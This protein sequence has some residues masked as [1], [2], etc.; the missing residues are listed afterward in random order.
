M[1]R[2]KSDANEKDT[3]PRV[4]IEGETF[5]SA[6]Q[7]VEYPDIEIP[8]TGETA[9]V[10]PGILW[11]RIPMPM[12]LN[13]INLWLLEDGDGWTLVDT[14]L[15]AEMC[16]EAWTM[17]AAKVFSGRPLK[18]IFVTHLHPDH[19]GLARWLQEAHKVPVWMSARGFGITKSIATEPTA[20][21]IAAAEAF[22]RHHGYL[23]AA[24]TTRFVSGKMYRSAISGVPEIAHSPNDGDDI[25]V[26]GANWRIYETNGHAEGHQCLHS[27]ERNILISGD[28]VLPT[29]SSNVSFSP[30]G[31]DSNPLASYLESLDRLGKLDAHT[32][33]LP[34]HGRPFYGLRF[35]TSDLIAHH[36][37]HLAAM[38]RACVQPLT[39]FDL[40]P[41]LFKRRL[42][43]SHWMFAMGE[44]IAH[45]EYL[46]QAG[47]MT[48]VVDG[49]GLIR[50]LHQS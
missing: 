50:Y 28:Q 36:R 20:D 13:H 35:R 11:V 24:L 37:D 19:V 21:E 48:R 8:A 2:P 39:A 17:L 27:S 18:R 26:G 9:I 16:K 47:E 44:T 1:T 29:I 40:V 4:T 15:N 5:A 38:K 49:D 22:M 45:A 3:A 32:L 6:P 10:A 34:S 12:D 23:D 7:R 42:I 25:Q 33:V 30:R 31:S 46:V 43:G 14:G 41:V